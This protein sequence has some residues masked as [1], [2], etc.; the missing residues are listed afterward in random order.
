MKK[1]T[2]T[3]ETVNAA[4]DGFLGME[5]NRILKELGA[6]MY[7]GIYP[8]IIRDLNGNKVGA[9]EY[10]TQVRK[11]LMQYQHQGEKFE[12]WET[13]KAD[14]QSV[15]DEMGLSQPEEPGRIYFDDDDNSYFIVNGGFDYEG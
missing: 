11:V 5:L 7:E 3:I 12:I 14:L 13:D 2:I 8:H 9:V 6:Q 4:F 10:E 1:V 15:W